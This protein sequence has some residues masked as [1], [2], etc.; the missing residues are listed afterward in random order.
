MDIRIKELIAGAKEAEGLTVIID[1]LRAFSLEA[2]LFHQGAERSYTIGDTDTALKLK[3]EHPDWIMIG[4]RGG[5]MIDGADFG[6]SPCEFEGMD[7]TG[8]TIIHTTSA[9]TQGIVNATG[10]SEII[11]G[12]LVNADA[13]AAYIKDKNPD[14][15]TLCAMGNAGVRRANE[16]LLCAE[17]I[18]SVLEGHPID[19]Q[20]EADKLPTNGA[21]HFF[22]PNQPQYPEP[23][24][25]RCIRCNTLNLV[26]GVDK[27]PEGLYTGTL[28]QGG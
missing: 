7:L 16:D 4:E 13:V 6:N 20:A 8:K 11:V 14:V 24:F 25:W 15:V 10:A 23:D 1:V 27:T 3:A 5:K 18:K 22:D 21:E 28:R 9:G 17:Y 19:V 12:A 26:I 2:Y